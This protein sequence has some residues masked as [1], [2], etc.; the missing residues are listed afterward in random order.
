MHN[1]LIPNDL[2][3]L[4]QF[5]ATHIIGIDEVGRGCLAGPIV[6]CGVV[7]DREKLEKLLNDNTSESIF[8]SKKVSKKGRLE[9]SKYAIENCLFFK[10]AERDNQFI[11]TNGIQKANI[12]VMVE[13]FEN[14]YDYILHMQDATSK[15]KL[16]ITKELTSITN[17][18]GTSRILV[19]SDHLNIQKH[20]ITNKE[21][22]FCN[23]MFLHPSKADSTYFTVACASIIA[24]EYRDKFMCITSHQKYPNYGFDTHV[25]YGTKKHIEKIKLHGICPIHRTSF[26]KK[27][28]S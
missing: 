28:L 23:I 7:F 8:D 9:L 3:I 13:G 21:K 14:C 16:Q 20:I 1:N 12:E 17:D 18:K 4:K 6:G 27:L 24:K 2:K 22:P 19:I 5:K 11:D 15:D 25:G 26:V 10:I